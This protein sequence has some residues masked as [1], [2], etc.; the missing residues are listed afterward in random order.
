M[1]A[2]ET[3]SIV[4]EAR[5]SPYHLTEGSTSRRR[6]R[7]CLHKLRK[8]RSISLTLFVIVDLRIALQDL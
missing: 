7:H 6:L 4:K 3:F 2:G 5:K 1:I 8:S